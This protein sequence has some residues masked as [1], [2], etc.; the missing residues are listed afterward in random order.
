MLLYHGLRSEEAA[1]LLVSDIQ[2]RRGLKHLQIHGKGGKLRYVRLHP[3]S[4][5]HIYTRT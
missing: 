1:H 4:A 3:V 5:E 2:E